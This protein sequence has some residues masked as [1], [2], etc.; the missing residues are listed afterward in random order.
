[1]SK[2]AKDRRCE[3][4]PSGK[5]HTCST[6]GKTGAWGKTWVW[7][8]NIEQ[9]D[10]APDELLKFC[11]AECVESMRRVRRLPKFEGF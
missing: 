3:E 10:A 5:M 7:F 4:V 8:G 9:L 11:S 2:R 1:M 6:C